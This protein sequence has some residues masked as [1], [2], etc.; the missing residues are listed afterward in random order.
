M[1][2]NVRY[3]RLGGLGGGDLSCRY[4]RGPAGLRLQRHEEERG[5]GKSYWCDSRKRLRLVS[6]PGPALNT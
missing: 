2:R 3:L 1:D 6:R 4:G 5:R